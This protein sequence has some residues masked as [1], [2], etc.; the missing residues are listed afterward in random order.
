MRGTLLPNN[1]FQVNLFSAVQLTKSVLP[2]MISKGNGIIINMSSVGGQW[3][4]LHQVHYA[5]TKAAIINFT[6][7]LAKSYAPQGIIAFAISPGSI[8]TEMIAPEIP[9]NEKDLVQFLKTIPI[10]RLGRPDEIADLVSFLVN[11]TPHFMVGHTFN[12]NGGVYFG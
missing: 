2:K 4:G 11:K 3:G 8:D 10:N 5:A 1:I 6:K 12:I 9:S 7:S